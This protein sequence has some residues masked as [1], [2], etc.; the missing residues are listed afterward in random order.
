MRLGITLWGFGLG[1]REAVDLARRAEDAGFHNLFMVESVL[2]NDGVITAAMMAA[3]TSRLLIGTNIANVYLRHPVMLGAAAVAIDEIAPERLV[4]GLGPN[5]RAMI[6]QAGFSWRDPREVL[7]ATT[8][9]LRAVF[10]GRGPARPAAS[11]AGEPSHPDPLG[12]HGPRDVR[13][14]GRP[15]RTDSCSTSTRPPAT[16]APSSAFA[17]AAK[18][19]GRDPDT[20]PV[21]L[22]IPTFIHDD[23]PTARQAA[24]EFL[25]H[26][27]RGPHYARTFAASGYA[28]EMDRVAKAW[29]AGDPATAMAALSD[30]L[31]DDVLLLGPPSRIREGIDRFARA[32][33]EWITMG[34]QAVA[35]DSLARQAERMIAALAPR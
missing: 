18:E 19:A 5:N 21:S 1:Y 29:A 35:T 31:L 9:T 23:L 22:L 4:L 24:R 11:A 10:T 17:R 30:A 27:A 34:P 8:A 2:S 20:L 3:R 33:V 13:G 28:D 25:V 16:D 6:T 7:Q 15:M 12:G 26:Y 14:G 32:G